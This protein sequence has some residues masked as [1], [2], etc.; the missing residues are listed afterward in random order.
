MGRAR[1]ARTDRGH[2]GVRRRRRRR[3]LGVLGAAGYGAAQG[4]GPD[5]PPDRRAS[6]SSG[7]PDDDGAYGAGAAASRSSC[8]VLG[9]SSAAG[10]G[11]RRARADRRRDHRHRRLPP[12]TGRPV[13]LTNVA[14][15]G[16]ESSDLDGQLANAA[17]PRCR[18]P[19][20]AVDHDRRQRRDP[21]DRQAVAVRHLAQAVRAPAR[22]RQPRSSSAPA[23]TSAP[24]SRCPSRCGCSAR[25]WSRDLAAAQTVA[26][27]EAGGRT[28]SLGDLLGP[29]FAARPHEMFSADR[30]HPSPAGYARPPRRCCPASAPRSACG[31]TAGTSALP[32]L[33][34]GEGVGP[35]AVRRRPGRARPRHRGQRPPQVGGQARGPRGRWAVLRRRPREPV[36]DRGEL[37]GEPD[38]DPGAEGPA[39]PDGRRRRGPTARPGRGPD[40]AHTP[41]RRTAIAST[42]A[43]RPKRSLSR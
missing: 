37:A 43:A 23:P 3:R 26:V 13:R 21:P 1:R 5:G 30:F 25:R 32:D 15:I 4:R 40:E 38:G 17:R 18:A 12:L 39:A 16:A 14:V 2:R 33:R 24:S 31:R 42:V 34:R 11:R 10:H 36:A 28:V 6:R 8:V 9:D 27:V 19:D 22:R 20:V 41:R 35:V 29:E 7:A